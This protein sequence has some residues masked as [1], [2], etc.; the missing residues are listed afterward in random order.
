MPLPLQSPRLTRL[1]IGPLTLL[2]LLSGLTL[3]HAQQ[4]PDAPPASNAAGPP[5]TALAPAALRAVQHYVGRWRGVGQP[6]RG[7][8]SGAWQGLT[9]HVCC[10]GCRDYFSEHPEEVLQEYRERQAQ[11]RASPRESK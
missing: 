7:S 2:T 9:Y 11:R 4:P 1:A 6:R 8:P 5:D 10:S 3:A